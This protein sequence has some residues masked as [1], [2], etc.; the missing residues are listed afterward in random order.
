MG[1]SLGSSSPGHLCPQV[2]NII[3]CRLEAGSDKKKK[4]EMSKVKINN[5]S[6]YLYQTFLKSIVL[7]SMEGIYCCTHRKHILSLKKNGS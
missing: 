6:I 2:P 4:Y 1:L 3:L 5:L 7:L